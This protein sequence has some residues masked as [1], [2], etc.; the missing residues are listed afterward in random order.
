MHIETGKIEHL[1]DD[2]MQ[3]NV[4]ASDYIPIKTDDMT[5]KQQ[6]NMQVSKYDNKSY[7][8]HLFTEH[9]KEVNEMK[10]KS[11]LEMKKFRTKR[12]AAKKARKKNRK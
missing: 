9:R 8:G 7:L 12:K 4:R 2:F 6:E 1:T 11:P 3:T 10:P 5:D